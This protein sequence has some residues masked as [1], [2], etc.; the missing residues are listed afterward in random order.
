[1]TP[2]RTQQY[3]IPRKEPCSEQA[4]SLSRSIEL[5]S[6][7]PRLLPRHM[8]DIRTANSTILL[9]L[10][11]LGATHSVTPAPTPRSGFSRIGWCNRVAGESAS[12]SGSLH[13]G[14]AASLWAP[15]HWPRYSGLYNER[16]AMQKST[17]PWPAAEHSAILSSCTFA[18]CCRA[19]G[20]ILAGPL[21]PDM[22]RWRS[23]STRPLL[24]R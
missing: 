21:C 14:P 13:P 5:P 11:I 6:N 10:Y 24:S 16:Q 4:L 8:M 17:C 22:S 20:T 19:D 18:V 7:R 15:L 12:P 9:T 1:M 3:R 2:S 23:I